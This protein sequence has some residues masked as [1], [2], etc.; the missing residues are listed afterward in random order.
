METITEN[1]PEIINRI[2]EP[3][4]INRETKEHLLSIVNKAL[5]WTN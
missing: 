4:F 5:D 3:G 2:L 1:L